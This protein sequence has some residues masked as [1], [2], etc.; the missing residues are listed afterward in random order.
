[1][2]E[3]RDLAFMDMAFALAEKALGRT[4]PNPHVGAVV[5]KTGKVVGFGHH[6]AAG[7]PHAEAA[8]LEKAGA[9]ARGACLYVT[10][11]PC[12]HWGRTPPCADAVIASGVGRVVLAALDP[13]PVVLGR[14]VRR[15][16]GAGIT[17]ETGARAGRHAR[18]NE[19]YAKW[20]ATRRPFVTLKAAL[21]LDGKMATKTYA[22]SWISSAATRSYLRLL[23]AEHDAVLVGAQTALRDDPRLTLRDPRRPGKRVVRVILDPKLRL[24]A[25]ARIFQTMA[26]GPLL[27]VAN[28]SAPAARRREVEAAGA[29]VIVLPGKG[30]RLDPGLILDCL[31]ARSVTSVLVEG[32]GAVATSFLDAR[33]PNKIIVSLSPRLIGGEKAVAFYSGR[34]AEALGEALRLSRVSTFRVG[35]DFIL[36][37]YV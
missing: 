1:M 26:E 28:E 12:V 21:S 5:V 10:L 14:G 24:P 2:I 34:G 7:S 32:G 16:R 27:L 25:G 20:I 9:L 13:N 36:E 31:G 3:A 35:P 11:E 17:V 6:E 23:R 4:S 19:G 18:L 29:E 37:G 15:I 33:L 30:N 8:A 22:A